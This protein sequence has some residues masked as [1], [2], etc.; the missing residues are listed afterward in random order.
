MLHVA[1]LSLFLDPEGRA[2]DD[3]LREWPSLA[4]TAE[5]AARAGAQVTVIQACRETTQR[6]R[7]GVRYEFLPPVA[8][9]MAALLARLQA[10]VLHLHGLAF[11]GQLAPL[12]RATACSPVLI[13]DHADRVPRPWRRRAWRRQL[14]IA[15]GLSFCSSEQA[16]PFER[17]ALIAPH[18]R[19]FEIAECSSAFVP[20]PQLAARERTGMHGDPALLWVGH[21]DMNKDPLT[22]LEAVSTLCPQFPGLH[23]WCC[24]GRA[25]LLGRVE[26]LVAREPRLA[27]R[28]H[29]L[30]PQPHAR[31]EELMRSADMFVLGSH[32][33]GSGYSVLEALACGLPPVITDIPSFRMLTGKGAV[34]ALWRAGDARHLTETLSNCLRRDPSAER[35]RVQHHFEHELA[36]AAYGTKLL[37]AYRCLAEPRHASQRGAS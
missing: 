3:I 23:L 5:A 28:V 21:L 15:S 29:L 9:D 18:T 25:P 32:R 4:M 22:V 12:L 19:I 26:Q 16:Q 1:Q 37:H 2:A 6:S 24:F 11:A 33:E 8:A 7:N 17:A 36:P 27:G 31:I 20:G 34:G 30:G 13:Q 35:A 14:G 10:D